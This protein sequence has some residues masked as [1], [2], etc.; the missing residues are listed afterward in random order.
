MALVNYK[1]KY[2]KYNSNV[3]IDDFKIQDVTNQTKT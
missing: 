2:A 1:Y 3:S